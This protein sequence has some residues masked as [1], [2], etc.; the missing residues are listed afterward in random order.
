MKK[1]LHDTEWCFECGNPA[2]DTHHLVNGPN[3]TNSEKYGLTVRLCRE[4]HAKLHDSDN[5]MA[6]RYKRIAQAAFEY[7]YSYEEWMEIFG[8]NYL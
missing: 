5:G 2:T 8:R 1:R 4:C 7:K 3:R 6:L